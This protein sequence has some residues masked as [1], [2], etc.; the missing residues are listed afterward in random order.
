MHAYLRV[1]A[2]TALVLALAAQTAIAHEGNPNFRSEIHGLEPPYPASRSRSST[3][4]TAC[5]CET[6]AT[7]WSWLRATKASHTS[8]SSPMERSR[9]TRTRRPSTSTRIASRRPRSPTSADASAPP[10]WRVANESGQYAWH[11]H[12][13]HYMAQRYAAAGHRRV[14][15]TEGL[16]L[17]DPAA[18]RRPA[19]GGAGTLVW[20]GEDDGCPLA[21]VHRPRSGRVDRCRRGRLHARRRRNGEEPDRPAPKEA[22]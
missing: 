9:S 21:A 11:D 8:G 13:A 16:R 17:R 2:L 6:K 7:A 12:R 3:S 19:R 18:G 22:W 15:R 10:D 4:T 14:E 5:S 20:V 1:G